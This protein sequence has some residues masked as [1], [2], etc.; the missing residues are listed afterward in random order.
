MQPTICLYNESADVTDEDAQKACAAIQRQLTEQFEP[1][2]K[3]TAIMHFAA[4]GETPVADAW[5]FKLVDKIDV[6]GALGY[7]T[8]QGLPTAFI[9]VPL[10]K[11][12]GVSWS[13]CL[14]HEVLEAVADPECI[15]LFAVNNAAYALEVCDPV[16]ASK[17]ADGTDY[18]IDGVVLENFILPAWFMPGSP[19]P[20]DFL[21]VL[22]AALARTD[23]GYDESAT[24]GEMSQQSGAK[25]RSAKLTAR[26]GSRRA[27]RGVK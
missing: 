21:G 20:Y 12:D 22:S 24:L 3:E 8:D 9:D 15:R 10:C 23:G 19:G 1:I 7:H 26:A 27:H 2:W 4:K 5:I 6:D 17:N 14:S 13:S 18:A 11:S 16:E 25:T